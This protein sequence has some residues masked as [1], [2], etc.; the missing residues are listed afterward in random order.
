MI[1]E[2]LFVNNAYDYLYPKYKEPLTLHKKATREKEDEK[3]EYI[4]SQ[5]SCQKIHGTWKI[6]STYDHSDTNQSWGLLVTWDIA[7]NLLLI[8]FGRTNVIFYLCFNK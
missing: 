2:R 5:K 3:S 1:W 6:L 7:V 4:P 8:L